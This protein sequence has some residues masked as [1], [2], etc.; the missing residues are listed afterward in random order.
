MRLERQAPPSQAYP[1]L[2]T[3]TWCPLSR[4]AGAFW[5]EAAHIADSRLR[6]LLVDSAEGHRVV[7][8]HNVAGT[9]CLI[10][11][12]TETIHGLDL[13]RAEAA[14]LLRRQAGVMHAT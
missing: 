3:A 9:P 2:V 5:R 8:A 1:T 4:A 7:A 14:A 6:L 11:S 12:P 10:L 13:S